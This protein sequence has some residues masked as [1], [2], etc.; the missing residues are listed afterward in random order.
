MATD[1][2]YAVVAAAIKQWAITTYGEWKESFIDSDLLEGAKVAVDALDAQRA[3]VA[4]NAA[5]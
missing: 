2:E 1:A 4:K 3:K 5:S